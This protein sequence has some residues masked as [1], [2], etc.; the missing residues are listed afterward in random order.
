MTFTPCAINWFLQGVCQEYG[1]WESSLLKS[2]CRRRYLYTYI[3]ICLSAT[4]TTALSAVW[5]QGK[6]LMICNILLIYLSMYSI[7]FLIHLPCWHHPLER[8]FSR[9]LYM[10]HSTYIYLNTSLSHTSIS[11]FYSLVTL[12]GCLLFLLFHLWLWA[13]HAVS[14]LCLLFCHPW[15]LWIFLFSGSRM[16]PVLLSSAVLTRLTLWP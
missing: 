9:H 10:N 3:C 4:M 6:I 13:C 2:K 7:P 8:N 11:Y 16:A 5:S 15:A 12:L 1:N 14:L